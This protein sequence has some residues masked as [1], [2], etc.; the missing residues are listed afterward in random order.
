MLWPFVVDRVILRVWMHSPHCSGMIM[1]WWY[2]PQ[3]EW[4]SFL[5][6]GI[7]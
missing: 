4:K 7:Y 5:E 2:R 6:E 3:H 1:F